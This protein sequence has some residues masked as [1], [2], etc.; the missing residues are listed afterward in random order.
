MHSG[1]IGRMQQAVRAAD[2]NKAPCPKARREKE[3]GA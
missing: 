2:K 3:G 1:G